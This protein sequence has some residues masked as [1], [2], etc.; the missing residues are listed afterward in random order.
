MASDSQPAEFLEETLVSRNVYIGERRT[1]IRLEPIFWEAL[2]RIADRENTTNNALIQSAVERPEGT[3]TSRVRAFILAYYMTENRR[4][5]Q[6]LRKF[7]AAR[8]AEP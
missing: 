5:T 8:S 6:L 7:V 4:Q 3:V 2:G 1:S